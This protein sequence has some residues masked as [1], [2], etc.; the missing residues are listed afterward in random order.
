MAT[1]EKEIEERDV[2]PYSPTYNQVRWRNTGQASECQPSQTVYR[3]AYISESVQKNDCAYGSGSSVLVVSEEGK[4]T[5]TVSQANADQQATDWLNANKQTIANG[6][7]SCSDPSVFTGVYI[8]DMEPDQEGACS[9]T[10]TIYKLYTPSGTLTNQRAYWDSAGREPL[11][12][13]YFKKNNG[14]TLYVLGGVIQQSNIK[15][16]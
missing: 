13:G 9:H 11:E 7:G 14:Y 2:N 15:C 4:F 1:G 3:S 10:Q 8:S 6:T 5:S 16:V 12:D